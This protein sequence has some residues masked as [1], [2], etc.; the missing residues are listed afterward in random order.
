MPPAHCTT[1]T[2]FLSSCHF[3]LFLSLATQTLTRAPARI[4]FPAL[5]LASPPPHVLL[6]CLCLSVLIARIM[7]QHR[8]YGISSLDK[9]RFTYSRINQGQEW[10]RVRQVKRWYLQLED[11]Q[12]ARQISLPSQVGASLEMNV[13]HP[14]LAFTA[15]GAKGSSAEL[16]APQTEGTRG[17]YVFSENSINLAS[18]SQSVSQSV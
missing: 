3:F 14:P 12:P 5:Y 18:P 6:T 13:Q 9:D 1:I 11:H 7:F 10:T 8:I 16:T 17:S 15:L 4:F 2:A